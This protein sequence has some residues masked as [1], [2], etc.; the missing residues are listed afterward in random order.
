MDAHHRNRS[1][2]ICHRL[3]FADFEGDS[4][5]P[6]LWFNDLDHESRI[7][8]RMT[9]NRRGEVTVFTLQL[10]F[11]IGNEWLPAVRYDTAHGEA[12]I[13]LIDPSGV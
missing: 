1:V 4:V 8:S 11:L 5:P 10:E 12:H 3:T 13:D 2:T 7:R 6:Q 9:T